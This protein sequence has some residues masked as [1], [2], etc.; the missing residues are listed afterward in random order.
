M[1]VKICGLTRSGDAAAAVAAGAW[2]IGV[3]LSPVGPRALDISRAAAVFAEAPDSVERV[4]VFV[5]PG[6]EDLERAASQLPLTRVQIHGELEE[7]A[8]SGIGLPIIRA[9]SF[10]SAAD[11][12]ALRPAEGE[13]TLLDSIGPGGVGGTGQVLDWQ[14]LGR[15]APSWPYVLA[16]GLDPENVSAAVTA[17]TP[18]AVDVSSGVEREPGIKDHEKMT[19]FIANAQMGSRL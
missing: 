11:L 10:E 9:R 4:G 15:A 18:Y 3:V 8:R 13:L 2:A 6:R 1:R 14:T 12:D 5:S 7:S 16:G 17:T 19:S